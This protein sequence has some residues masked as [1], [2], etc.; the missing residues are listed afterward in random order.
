[1]KTSSI[2]SNDKVIIVS[3]DTYTSLIPCRQM[4]VQFY[5]ENNNEAKEIEELRN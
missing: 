2:N 1:M 5:A 4:C 3:T